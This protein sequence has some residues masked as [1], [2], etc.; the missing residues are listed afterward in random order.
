VSKL[1]EV[2]FDDPSMRNVSLARRHELEGV[3]FVKDYVKTVRFTF[4]SQSKSS[5]SLIM[6]DFVQ[7][8]MVYDFFKELFEEFFSQSRK[9]KSLLGIIVE[10][11]WKTKDKENALLKIEQTMGIDWR[12]AFE[13][14]FY[15]HEK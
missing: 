6:E 13:T 4:Y 7:A 12:N 15:V 10:W 3:A 2:E 14:I 9:S 11:N 1:R 5:L 8:K